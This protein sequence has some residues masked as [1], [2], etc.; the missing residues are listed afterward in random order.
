MTASEFY[1]SKTIT[2]AFGRSRTFEIVRHLR[3]V[4][5]G[6]FPSHQQNVNTYYAAWILYVLAR[7]RHATMQGVYQAVGD[8]RE[9]RCGND[10]F[11]V[12]L[13]DLLSNPQRISNE[14]QN[15][16]VF[17]RPHDP[18]VQVTFTDGT[19]KIF[20][21]RE[22][23]RNFRRMAVLDKE[24]LIWVALLLQ[25]TADENK[26]IV[27]EYDGPDADKPIDFKEEL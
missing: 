13:G 18:C 20:Q 11:V 1:Q 23:T 24:F 7:G 27:F 15:V 12:W 26:S 10:L 9:L 22:R 21:P 3:S 2:D 8:G 6:L 17:E 5:P 16:Y 14:I 4:W 25:L 19:V